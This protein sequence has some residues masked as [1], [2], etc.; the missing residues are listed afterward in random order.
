METKKQESISPENMRHVI[1]TCETLRNELNDAL[2]KTGISYPVE[3]LESG[4]HNTPKVLKTKLDE[5]L[6][7][8]D[9]DRVLLGIGFCGNSI[10]GI[11]AGDFELII[12][13]V[14]DC[15]SLLI[16]SVKRRME[17]S[18]EYAAYFLTEG[19]LRGER[20]IW[21]EYTYAAEKYGE[22]LAQEMIEMM[23][24]NYRTLGLLDTG[25]DDISALWDKS[26]VI[27]ETLNLTR[28]TIPASTSYL[29]KLL[30]GPWPEE[31]FIVKAPG[32]KVTMSDLRVF[33]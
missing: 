12:P 3:W 15:I 33:H 31:E 32:E 8:V 1:I 28:Q 14:D 11:A 16:G 27:A 20:N 24:G 30:T 18:S 29:Q 23:L 17:I 22:E 19:W 2:A 4:L 6:S 7:A 25:V 9:A 21:V 10:E 26:E 13:R 5:V